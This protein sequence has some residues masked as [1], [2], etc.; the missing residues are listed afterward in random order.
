MADPASNDNHVLE[1][2]GL[3]LLGTL[4]TGER[5][6][7]EWHLAACPTCLI[8]ADDLANPIEALILLPTADR[9]EFTADGPQTPADH[10]DR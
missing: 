6:A 3:Y 1:S 10:T 4:T 7:V 8:Q 9:R 5:Q 2:L